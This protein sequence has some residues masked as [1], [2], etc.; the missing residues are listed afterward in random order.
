MPY[1]E[2]RP[3]ITHWIGPKTEREDLD[4]CRQLS[5]IKSFPSAD[6]RSALLKEEREQ[7][8]QSQQPEE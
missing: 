5:S 6:H 7:A 1:V 4:Q 3:G 8:E 2:I